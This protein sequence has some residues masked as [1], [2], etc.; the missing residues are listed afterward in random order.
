[1]SK[2]DK[3]GTDRGERAIVEIQAAME[4][5]SRA[6][7]VRVKITDETVQGNSVRIGGRDLTNFG[8]CSYLGLGQDPRFKDAATAAVTRFGPSYSSS[9]AYASVDLYTELEGGL[10]KMLS[11][12]CVIPAPTTTLAHLAALP[13]LVG[14]H[15]TVVMD[16]QAHASLHLAAD[17][18]RGRG[19]TIKLVRHNDMQA[20]ESA[21]E[22]LAPSHRKVWYL[23]DGVYSMHGDVA[24]VAEIEKLMERFQNLHVYYDDAHGFGWAGKNGVGYVLER[25]TLNERVVVAVSLS[26]SFG[27]GGGA[28]I[29]SDEAT[30]RRILLTGG[31]LTFGGPI[32]PAVLAAGVESTKLH[33]S[34]EH[35][36]RQQ[37]LFERIDLVNSL[38]DDYRLPGPEP[39]RTPIGFMKVGSIERS[40][41]CAKYM[42]V[43]GFYVNVAGY[44]AVPR[45]QG[46]VRFTVTAS[47][48]KD[49][50]EAFVAALAAFAL[51]PERVNLRDNSASEAPQTV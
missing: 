12:A 50:I 32:H 25:A 3:M 29:L 41:R 48:S 26:K 10:R 35:A 43:Q 9:A 23:A 13:V 14:S 28:I 33:L 49:D 18:L 42:M 11:G 15:D 47:H 6:G 5:A 34:S 1:M 20:L 44:P 22:T 30:A 24:P 7:V 17:V 46:G 16:I 40:I 8:S 2:G 36:D 38:M 31:T 21:L 39:H 4:A 27:A 37:M 19:V 45:N 51:P